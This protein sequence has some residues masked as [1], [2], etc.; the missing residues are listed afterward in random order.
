[1][2]MVERVVIESL[3]DSNPYCTPDGRVLYGSDVEE[4]IEFFFGPDV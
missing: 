4:F 3:I 1:M 2:G